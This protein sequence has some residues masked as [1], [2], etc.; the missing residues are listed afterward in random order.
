MTGIHLIWSEENARDLVR[1][2]REYPRESKMPSSIVASISLLL[3]QW[4]TIKESETIN[5]RTP[6]QSLKGAHCFV[7][8]IPIEVRIS[9]D[10]NMRK[11][12][13]NLH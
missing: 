12:I 13:L 6:K 7:T 11:Q 9:F 1:E 5:N 3:C 2:L 10:R 8:A 4:E